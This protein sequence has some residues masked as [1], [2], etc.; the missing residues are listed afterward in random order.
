[1]YNL[2]FDIKFQGSTASVNLLHFDKIRQRPSL[3]SKV[4]SKFWKKIMYSKGLS[5]CEEIIFANF[6]T[7]IILQKIDPTNMFRY[8]NKYISHHCDLQNFVPVKKYSGKPHFAE[9]TKYGACENSHLQ[10]KVV[11]FKLF[12]MVANVYRM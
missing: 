12:K 4:L 8:G 5:L 10:Y 3:N 6:A 7:R 1:M 11:S 2:R 9:F